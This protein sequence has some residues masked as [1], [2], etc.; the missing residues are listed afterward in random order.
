[1]IRPRPAG[2]GSA[3]AALGQAISLAFILACGAADPATVD[4]PLDGPEDLV[5]A[6]SGPTQVARLLFPSTSGALEAEDREIPRSQDPAL[7]ARAILEQLVIG[8]NRPGSYRG[9][10][11]DVVIGNIVLEADGRISVDFESEIHPSPPPS[12]SHDEYLTL[13]SIVDSLAQNIPSVRSVV[14]LWNGRQP[15]TFGGHVDTSHPLAPL[16]QTTPRQP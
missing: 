7:L 11:E 8:P 2:L 10:P 9:L 15:P 4:R 13:Y 12:G 5:P 1:M 16:R 14:V 6:P 3:T